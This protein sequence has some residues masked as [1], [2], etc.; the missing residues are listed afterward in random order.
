MPEHTNIYTQVSIELGQELA[1]YKKEAGESKTTPFGLEEVTPETEAR[2]F[3][4]LA[5]EGKKAYMKQH[6]VQKTLDVL[7]RGM[8]HGAAQGR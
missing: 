2:R 1:R 6:G 5:G 7:R 4:A 3:M 8:K